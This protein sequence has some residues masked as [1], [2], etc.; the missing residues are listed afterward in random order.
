[1]YDPEDLGEENLDQDF[2][3]RDSKSEWYLVGRSNPVMHLPVKIKHKHREIDKFA[4]LIILARIILRN[5]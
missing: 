3:I 4:R 5:L 1:M 2:I